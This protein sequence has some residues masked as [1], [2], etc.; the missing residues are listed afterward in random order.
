M[1]VY[2]LII[3]PEMCAILKYFL[4]P[5]LYVKIFWSESIFAQWFGRLLW[6][7]SM[8]EKHE[9]MVLIVLNKLSMLQLRTL[10]SSSFTLR[11]M[12]LLKW[13]FDGLSFSID[14]I[15]CFIDHFT[16]YKL[17]WLSTI[18][19]TLLRTSKNNLGSSREEN[20]LKA[21]CLSVDD[22]HGI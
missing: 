7:K 5:R 17:L 9:W 10:L 12:I 14:L 8:Y 6:Y 1:L 22:S 20:N 3:R 18:W 19:H 4:E 15:V 2:F 13:Q 21:V 11:Y 16:L